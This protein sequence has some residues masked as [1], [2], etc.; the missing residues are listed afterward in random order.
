MCIRD[1]VTTGDIGSAVDVDAS[2]EEALAALLRDDKG[3]VGV[4]DGA[5]FLGVLTPAGIHQQLRASLL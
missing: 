5:Q 2:L 4:K 1:S 3:V